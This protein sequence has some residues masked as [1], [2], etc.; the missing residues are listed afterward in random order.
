MEFGSAL[1][2]LLS[3]RK[4]VK[5]SL[6]HQLQVVKIKFGQDITVEMAFSIYNNDQMKSNLLYDGKFGDM[7]INVIAGYEFGK[8]FQCTGI[9][10][11]WIL[12][13][14]KMDT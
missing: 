13:V 4:R 6:D 3:S 1:N 5:L 14:Y 11:T 7:P 8:V 9:T 2:G 12:F 10:T